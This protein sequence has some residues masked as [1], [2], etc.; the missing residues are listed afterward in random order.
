M[1]T[2]KSIDAINPEWKG[3]EPY[4]TQLLL[5]PAPLASPAGCTFY[6]EETI[7]HVS[8]EKKCLFPDCETNNPDLCKAAITHKMTKK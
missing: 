2:Q 8:C 3:N 7:P 5:G 1:I 6:H 4:C